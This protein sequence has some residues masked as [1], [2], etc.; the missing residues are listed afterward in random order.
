MSILRT[1]FRAN[2]L[3]KQTPSLM[4]C[5]LECGAFTDTTFVKTRCEVFGPNAKTRYLYAVPSIQNWRNFRWPRN[6]GICKCNVIPQSAFFSR[7]Y[8]L[9]NVSTLKSSRDSVFLGGTR[10]NVLYRSKCC[11]EYGI[12]SIASFS[13]N[14]STS[15]FRI[16]IGCAFALV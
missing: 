9:F 12:G 10:K 14:C 8:T 16:F 1:A 4:L 3:S 11:S 6:T 7:F 5:I 15:K 13:N 2:Q